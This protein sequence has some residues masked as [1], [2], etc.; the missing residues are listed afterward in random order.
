MRLSRARLVR[1][2]LFAML[3]V[4]GSIAKAGDGSESEGVMDCRH[5]AARIETQGFIPVGGIEQWIT[6]RGARCDN[7]VILVVHGGPGT[8]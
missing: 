2:C 3:C 8:R 5:A 4:F 1:R 7:P 6:I